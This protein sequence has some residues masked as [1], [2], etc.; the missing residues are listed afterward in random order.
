MIKILLLLMEYLKNS[1]LPIHLNYELT[2]IEAFSPLFQL[3]W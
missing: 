3:D 2:N 1:A